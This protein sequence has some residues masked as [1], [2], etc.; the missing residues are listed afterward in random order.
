MTNQE[1]A[2]DVLLP[3]I[4]RE[5]GC[6]KDNADGAVQALADDGLLLPDPPEQKWTGH[7]EVDGVMITA[8]KDGDVNLEWRDGDYYNGEDRLLWLNRK[9][10]LAIIAAANLAKEQ[11]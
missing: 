1:R 11:K 9:Q 4:G 3:W 7:W 8:E 10:V 6:P 5:R 2:K